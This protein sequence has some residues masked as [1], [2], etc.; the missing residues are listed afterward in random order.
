MGLFKLFKKIFDYSGD[1]IKPVPE[2]KPIMPKPAKSVMDWPSSFHDEPE[3]KSRRERALDV[4]YTPI[5]IDRNGEGAYFRSSDGNEYATT[6][7]SC[8]CL[9]FQRRRK[10]CKHMYRLAME[11]G[12]LP[13]IKE[14]DRCKT[15]KRT[16]EFWTVNQV[17]DKISGLTTEEMDGFAYICY[18]CGN[19]NKNGEFKAD[20]KLCD[21]LYDLGLIRYSSNITPSLNVIT[22][23][24][25]IELY[26]DRVEIN[27]SMKKSE[28][29]GMLLNVITL[30]D[31]P[32]EYWR[33][34]VTLSPEIA[35]DANK[36][37]RAICKITR[38]NYDEN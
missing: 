25:L 11:L 28:M 15:T 21:K 6:L 16:G 18:K 19:N 7:D 12:Y 26:S 1:E 13:G 30:S 22:K 17:L 24:K 8:Q 5:V 2:E 29:I 36:I 20:A 33:P 34:F 27:S 14:E 37:H 4:R 32:K 9:D 10:P 38:H 23:A 3:Q 35:N 31:I